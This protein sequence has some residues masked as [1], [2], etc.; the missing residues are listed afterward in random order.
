MSSNIA[1]S[2]RD[3]LRTIVSQRGKADSSSSIL[4]TTLIRNGQ[5][6]GQRFSFAGFSLVWFREEGQ[7]KFYSPLGTLEHSCTVVQFCMLS[8][9]SNPADLRRVA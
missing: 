9:Q 8:S 6:C 4:E 2:L 1:D 3:S 7:V 5:Y